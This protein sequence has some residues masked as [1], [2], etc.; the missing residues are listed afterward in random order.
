MLEIQRKIQ[1]STDQIHAAEPDLSKTGA[2][3]T[4]NALC[5]MLVEANNLNLKQKYG[6]YRKLTS[7]F[8]CLS[9]HH[10]RHFTRHHTV[11]L[12]LQTASYNFFTYADTLP[13]ICEQTLMCQGSA[14]PILR[15]TENI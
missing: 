6:G 2:Y 1:N 5:A 9:R 12:E 15:E 14:L 3:I 11:P 8:S 7:H 13:N 10:L 4:H